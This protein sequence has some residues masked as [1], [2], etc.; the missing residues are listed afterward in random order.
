[1]NPD[2]RADGRAGGGRKRVFH[3]VEN[4]LPL[5][6]KVGETGFHC[7]ENFSKPVSMVWENPRNTLPLCGKAAGATRRGNDE[8]TR[9]GGRGEDAF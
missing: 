5:C 8:T 6:G 1:M 7:V 9:R 4:W 3:G 2:G